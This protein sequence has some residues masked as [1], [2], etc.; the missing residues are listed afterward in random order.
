[1]PLVLRLPVNL[2]AELAVNCAEL[3]TVILSVDTVVPVTLVNAYALYPDEFTP[4]ENELDD[5][6]VTVYVLP[7]RSTMP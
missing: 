1:M 2:T 3:P 7:F 6:R 4:S 5:I